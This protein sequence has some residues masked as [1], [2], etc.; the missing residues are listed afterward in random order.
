[1][2]VHDIKDI[3]DLRSVRL[4]RLK[5]QADKVIVKLTMIIVTAQF[6]DKP[7]L[8]LTDFTSLYKKGYHSFP[9]KS[10]SD[11]AQ[12]FKE[13][14]K[15]YKIEED[16]S[17]KKVRGDTKTHFLDNGYFVLVHVTAEAYNGTT[18]ADFIMTGF[19]ILNE[20]PSMIKGLSLIQQVKVTSL[21][22]AIESRYSL[23]NSKNKEEL[24]KI[25]EIIKPSSSTASFET[26]IKRQKIDRTSQESN[27]S[28]GTAQELT[29]PENI[30]PSPFPS[31]PLFIPPPNSMGSQLPLTQISDDFCYS[32]D[33]VEKSEASLCVS[34]NEQSESQ[35]Q[36]EQT[37]IDVVE[38]EV[39]HEMVEENGTDE[40]VVHEEVPE[41]E[42][43]QEETETEKQAEVDED[44]DEDEEEDDEDDPLT[45]IAS[46]FKEGNYLTEGGA[47]VFHG[48]ILG[49]EPLNFQI[50][51]K[52]FNSTTIN[53]TGFRLLL[54]NFP[55]NMLRN[56]KINENCIAVEFSSR[57][58]IL[59]FFGYDNIEDAYKDQDKIQKKLEALLNRRDKMSFTIERKFYG[60]S[61]G[62]KLVFEL[63]D[64]I[65]Y[66]LDQ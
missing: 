61:K 12:H 65:D 62:K 20:G 22:K 19:K 28:N 7:V 11:A 53:T 38:V 42:A 34:D 17:K 66:L 60:M 40:S 57:D 48:Y 23:N 27:S 51:G 47:V 56:M 36:V 32:Q 45:A 10:G 39:K 1:M 15:V 26:P 3:Q 43:P 2:K 9:V 58:Q 46:A 41:T 6:G 21:I 16:P 5:E 13:L 8:E 55:P 35:V 63:T 25:I 49:S 4:T 33:D 14:K 30:D 64:T 18:A 54:T 52:P 37:Q 31:N 50:I 29:P 24:E 59:S 44:E